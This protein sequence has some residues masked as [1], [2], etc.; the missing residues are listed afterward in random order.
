[1]YRDINITK[2]FIPDQNLFTSTLSNQLS[3]LA[4][5]TGN[6]EYKYKTNSLKLNDI[7]TLYTLEQCTEILNSQECISC[8][9][10]MISTQIPWSFLGSVG[11]R[12]IYPNC[13]LRFELFQFY[14]K[15]ED[16]SPKNPSK[17]AGELFVHMILSFFIIIKYFRG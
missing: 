7:Q 15:S 5:A 6:S 9:N 14:L 17:E 10:D 13:N 16:R 2:H 4:N 8:L 3:E 12:I 11:G 1:M